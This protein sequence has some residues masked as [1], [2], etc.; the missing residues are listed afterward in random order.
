ML[1]RVLTCVSKSRSGSSAFSDG[2]GTYT[3]QDVEEQWTNLLHL[4]RDLPL[5]E[6]TNA[7]STDTVLF[8]G[9]E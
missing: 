4:N 8:A 7:A 2:G 9:F 3:L 5:W 6:V 1:D